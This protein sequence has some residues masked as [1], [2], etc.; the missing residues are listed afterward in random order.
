MSLHHLNLNMNMINL[1]CKTYCC[2]FWIKSHNNSSFT[3]GHWCKSSDA[4]SV[5][6]K[7]IHFKLMYMWIFCCAVFSGGWCFLYFQSG[8]D[9]WFKISRCSR[10]V[11]R[12]GWRL[13]FTN[14]ANLPQS[15]WIN[16]T[17][18]MDFRLIS[19]KYEHNAITMKRCLFVRAKQKYCTPIPY[20][21]TIEFTKQY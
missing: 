11:C 6:T 15:G 8:V 18:Q 14:T 9:V 5:R 13:E 21:D 12:R 19:E 20:Q 7:T 4:T 1:Q 10:S 17:A 3:E 2:T 16:S